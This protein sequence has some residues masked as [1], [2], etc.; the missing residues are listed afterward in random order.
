MHFYNHKDQGICLTFPGL[1]WLGYNENTLWKSSTRNSPSWPFIDHP[2]D[3]R[4]KLLPWAALNDKRKGE[5]S[6]KLRQR[7]GC[8]HKDGEPCKCGDLVYYT[9]TEP[10]RN[11]IVKDLKA[12]AYYM[13]YRYTNA[14]GT[15]ESLPTEKVRHYTNEAS[16]MNMIVAADDDVKGVVKGQLGF[17]HVSDFWDRVIDLIKQEKAKG[18][19]SGKFP[20]S[21]V[22]LIS[23]KGSAVKLYRE[24]GY[25]SLIHGNYGKANAA[26]VTDKVAEDQLLKLIEDPRQLDDVFVSMLYSTWAEQN[27]YK[28][29][30]PGTV[31]N[32][33]VERGYET[34]LG[35]YGVMAYNEK[36]V[37]QTKGRRP[38]G[39][40]WMVEHDDNNLDFLFQ[41]GKYQFAR[42]VAIVV[43]DSHCDLVL[44]KSYRQGDDPEQWQVQQ[45]YLDAMY[46]IRSLTGGWHLPFEIKS[47]NWA[48][49]SLTRFYEQIALRVPAGRG[50]KHRGYI[51][52]L[53][54]SPH[55]KRAQQTVSMDNWNANNLTAKNAGVNPDM[56]AQSLKDKTRPQVG[57][58]AERQIEQFFTLV[59]KMP[60]FTRENMNAPSKEAQWLEAWNNTHA[61]DKRPITDEMFLMKFGITHQPKHTDSITITNRGIEPQI[62]GQRLSYDLPEQWMYTRLI[63]AKVQLM[64]DPY[65]MSRVLATN[66]D[67]IR[68]IARTAQVAPRALHDAYTGSRAFLNAVLDEKKEQ[69]N[70]AYAAQDSRRL[71]ANGYPAA[72]ALLKSGVFEKGVMKAAEQ[73]LISGGK[74]SP[75]D[76]NPLDLM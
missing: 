50:N 57:Y 59:Q 24:K 16:L 66:H 37:R 35:R 73:T 20:T 54:G 27:G 58:E 51:E 38:G 29:I 64:Y 49:K 36:Y 74:Q 32:Y 23:T 62:R 6:D 12:E 17:K 40:L 2:D 33:R 43:A 72:E 69:W 68:F 65:D 14:N 71:V 55:W 21:Y 44:G 53:F 15:P 22:R 18:H 26:K 4:K 70:E 1:V 5:I 67:D 63:G 11:L 9:S 45:A 56:L 42:Y 60:A 34:D 48:V 47:D 39:P 76:F 25:D 3:R 10:I 13:A 61:D 52:Q 41:D 19:V 7:Q 75:A 31:R 8:A 28:A 46:Y 30:G